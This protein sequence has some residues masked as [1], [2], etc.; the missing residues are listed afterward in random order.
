MN[1]KK[2]KRSFA[3]FKVF[4]EN[5]I[6]VFFFRFCQ[7]FSLN[8]R[9]KKSRSLFSLFFLSWKWKSFTKDKIFRYLNNFVNVS[10]ICDKSR[11]FALFNSFVI[12]TISFVEKYDF[13]NFVT[14]IINRFNVSMS[15]FLH[16][17]VKSKKRNSVFVF[18]EFSISDSFDV[19]FFSTLFDV[20][21]AFSIRFFDSF[22]NDYHDSLFVRR[23]RFFSKTFQKRFHVSIHFLINLK[24]ESVKYFFNFWK[25]QTQQR[26]LLKFSQLWYKSEK[27]FVLVRFVESHH[28]WKLLCV[29]C[30]KHDSICR[31]NYKKIC[32]RCET[33][34]VSC[35]SIY[36]QI[37]NDF[38]FR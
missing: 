26:K 7:K 38:F 23:F 30:V 33:A 29:E 35:R 9:K 31:K 18:V 8:F 37:C 5:E 21:F 1:E 20:V 14:I 2:R 32:E 12:S 11:H 24:K 17:S 16:F 19:V 28:D 25:I 3:R 6:F 34:H 36:I 22:S 4:V 10:L 27:N 13:A 15:M